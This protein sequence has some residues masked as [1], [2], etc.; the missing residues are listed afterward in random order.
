MKCNKKLI[1]LSLLVVAIIFLITQSGSGFSNIDDILSD[2]YSS[3]SSSSSSGEPNDLEYVCGNVDI[4]VIPSGRL[5]G[6]TI[7]LT[8][9]EKRNL[10]R[11]FIENG[12]DDVLMW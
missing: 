8:P 11:R 7:L 9:S 6:S 10:L 5:P 1:I 2:N 3:S 4:R 12:P